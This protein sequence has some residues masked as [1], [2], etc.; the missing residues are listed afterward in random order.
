[1]HIFMALGHTNPGPTDNHADLPPLVSVEATGVCI[2]VG[3]S[4]VLLP[5]V[6]KSPGKAWRDA[7]IT[8]LISFRR[9]SILAGN[10]NS[11]HPF[12][13]SRFSNT[14]GEKL[15]DLF[16]VNKFEISAP[17]YPTHY[18]P[19]GNG[20]VLDIVDHKNI[21]MSDAIVS[22]ILDSDHLLIEFRILNHVK[23]RNISEPIEKFTDL[24][25]FASLASELISSKIEIKSGVET[26][27]AAHV[28]TASI[29]SAY[30]LSTRKV[31][32]SDIDNYFPGLDHF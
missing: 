6:Y 25:R 16:D 4:E 5:A 15:M 24:D 31:T 21:R 23:I 27:K 9:K 28:F 3:K 14:S 19:G 26:D 13:N 29:A 7:D 18:S 22:D 30:R 8:E 2:P 1:M 10:L 11:K 12:W 17:Q 32:L 20:D